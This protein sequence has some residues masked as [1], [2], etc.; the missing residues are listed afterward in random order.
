MLDEECQVINPNRQITPNYW[1]NLSMSQNLSNLLSSYL[2][3]QI[4]SYLLKKV[5]TS[6]LFKKLMC[7]IR[8]IV[9]FE[10]KLSILNI[11]M[12]VTGT[13]NIFSFQKVLNAV[14]EVLWHQH[15]GDGDGDL[16]TR[17][18]CWPKK[19]STRLNKL[20]LQIDFT[21]RTISVWCCGFLKITI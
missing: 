16:V 4:S 3:K 9:I 6:L 7:K 21:G 2:S 17:T 14:K 10:L 15:V 20:S 12:L 8:N 5:V 19:C 1:G 11:S 18:H 13:Q